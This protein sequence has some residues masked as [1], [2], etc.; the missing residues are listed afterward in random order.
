MAVWVAGVSVPRRPRAALERPGNHRARDQGRAHGRRD[1]YIL[2]VHGPFSQLK[3]RE[4]EQ[5]AALR[6]HGDQWLM[7]PDTTS[8]PRRRT[9]SGG[10]S[11][12]A[13]GPRWGGLSSTAGDQTLT[14]R[15]VPARVV[16]DR[17]QAERADQRRPEP[18]AL[19]GG[20]RISPGYVTAHVHLDAGRHQLPAPV[21]AAVRS[22][23]HSGRSK[24]CRHQRN[25]PRVR[26]MTMPDTCSVMNSV[27]HM[28][29][30]GCAA[31]GTA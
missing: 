27:D 1:R 28:H 16:A 12:P 26:H 8:W 6:R 13:K 2:L 4:G 21:A 23:P 17:T 22:W 14:L 11:V 19:D 29:Q 5:Y 18:A 10:L 31:P 9:R 15:A 20:G 24:R 3:G 30:T 7:K 25:S